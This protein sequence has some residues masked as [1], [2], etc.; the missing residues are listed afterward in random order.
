MDFPDCLTLAQ[1]PTPIERVERWPRDASGV[2]L[3]VKRDDLTGAALSGNKIRK[4]EFALAEAQAADVDVVL[5]CGGAMS[6]HCRATA[7]V[8]ARLGLRCK[9]L[10]RSADGAPVESAGNLLLSQLAG[11]E[12]AWTTPEGYAD[13]ETHLHQLARE[14]ASAG[15]RPYVIPEGASNAV[16]AL[17]YA[18]A[19]REIVSQARDDELA[20]DAV[21]HA[22]GSGGTTAGLALGMR[23]F[24]SQTRLLAITSGD[25]RAHM[26]DKLE[27]ILLEVGDR[28]GAFAPIVVEEQI[29]VLDQYRA[30]GHGV[31]PPEQLAVAAALTRASGLVLDPVYGAKAFYG[32]CREI[33]AGNIPAGSKVLFIHTGGV[34]G[35]FGGPQPAEVLADALGGAGA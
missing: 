12:L 18:K 29:E 5:T 6:N 30:G 3:Y 19:W 28:F 20:F 11:A 26:N 33:D 21:V 35:W 17:G 8:A 2:Q 34:F 16:G 31:A 32:L 4:L 15:R 1:L 22:C 7:L 10:L 25:E 14:E 23:L 9:L 24:G 27:S 13:R